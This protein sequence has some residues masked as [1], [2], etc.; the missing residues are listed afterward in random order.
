MQKGLEKR[1][2][3]FYNGFCCFHDGFNLMG[4]RKKAPFYVAIVNHEF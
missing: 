2:P 4:L 3:S 1:K